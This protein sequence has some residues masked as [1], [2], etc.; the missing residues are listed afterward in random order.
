MQSD[1][2][3]GLVMRE[4]GSQP[5]HWQSLK[6][7]LRKWRVQ[8]VVTLEG[9]PS[10]DTIPHRHPHKRGSTM[11][12]VVVGD[13]ILNVTSPYN[14]E[15]VSFA[16]MRGGKWSDG[17]KVWMF[18]PRDEFA[19]RSTLIDIFGTDDYEQAKK[20][21]VR[22]KLDHFDVGGELVLFGRQLLRRKYRDGKVEIDNG[23]ITIQG[24]YAWSGGSGRYPL[25]APE[26]GTV[27]EV[28][29]VPRDIAMRTW[30]ENKEAIELLGDISVE[31]LKD[32][33]TALLN[34]IEQIN[35]M[36]ADLEDDREVDDL[37]DLYD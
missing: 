29:D 18:D 9:Q 11:I 14:K 21:S 27:I 26:D 3:L 16:R 31:A 24:E 30:A 2:P 25:I 23:V 32:E 37:A 5:P 17:R 1:S 15:F 36:I 10:R 6:S 12:K 28:R 22:V 34:R 8:S 7:R 20:V 13:G 4:S 35:Q 19:V 33:K